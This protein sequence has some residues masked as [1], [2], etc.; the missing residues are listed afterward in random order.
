MRSHHIRGFFILFVFVVALGLVDAVSHAQGWNQPD[1]YPVDE[2]D[3]YRTELHTMRDLT[4]ADGGLGYRTQDP[5]Q[6]GTTIVVP[7]YQ[8]P[9]FNTPRSQT[10]HVLTEDGGIDVVPMTVFPTP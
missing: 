1:V 6:R 4:P 9:R 10:L 3:I 2:L 8:G 7:Q 5:Y